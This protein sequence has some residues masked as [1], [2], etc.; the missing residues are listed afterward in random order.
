MLAVG[1]QDNKVNFYDFKMM[2]AGQ[3]QKEGKV[4]VFEKLD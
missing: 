1:K 2:M 3:Q 4:I